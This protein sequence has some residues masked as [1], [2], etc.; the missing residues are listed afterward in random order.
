MPRLLFAAVAFAS[1][2]ILPQHTS[3][4]H[5]LLATTTNSPSISDPSQIAFFETT[6]Q[7]RAG[8]YLDSAGRW[9][10]EYNRVRRDEETNRG[11]DEDSFVYGWL[12]S[13]V[14]IHNSV[15]PIHYAQRK[16]R[17]NTRRTAAFR[18]CLSSGA[19]QRVTVKVTI[20]RVS[21]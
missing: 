17:R 13:Q 12:A 16:K 14:G 19:G 7:R 20:V 9:L 1:I 10:R 8:R 2:A 4:D 21:R 5:E 18:G 11:T 6:E 3:A 15:Q